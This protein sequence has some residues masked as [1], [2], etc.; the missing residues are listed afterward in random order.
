[1]NEEDF[2]CNCRIIYEP[3]IAYLFQSLFCMEAGTQFCLSTEP[4][5]PLRNKAVCAIGVRKFELALD[6]EEHVLLHLEEVS[7]K[8]LKSNNALSVLYTAWKA[9][10]YAQCKIHFR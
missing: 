4:C 5:Q 2:V 8:V 6:K 9:V 3:E 10:G 7:Q 1:M